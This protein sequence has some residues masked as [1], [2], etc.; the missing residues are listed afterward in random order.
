MSLILKEKQ[1]ISFYPFFTFWKICLFWCQYYFWRQYNQPWFMKT[2]LMK[3]IFFLLSVWF[4]SDYWQLFEIKAHSSL[5]LQRSFWWK[6]RRYIHFFNWNG[7]FFERF[8]QNLLISLRISHNSIF[9]ISIQVTYWNPT[10]YNIYSHKFWAVI[11]LC[12]SH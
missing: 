12:Y 9:Y 4:W 2:F 1:F 11:W 3:R 7:Y 10:D 8:Q 6:K 5:G